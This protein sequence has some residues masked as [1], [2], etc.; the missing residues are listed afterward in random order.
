MEALE[1]KF[2]IREDR[3]SKSEVIPK[4]KLR[5]LEEPNDSR[6]EPEKE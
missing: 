6:N 1:S 3:G 2:G 4:G 5:D